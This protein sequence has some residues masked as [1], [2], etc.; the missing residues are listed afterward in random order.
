MN[1][2]RKIIHVDMDCFFAAV[3]IRDNPHLKGRA[4][5]VGGNPEGR[6]VLTTANYE[7]RKYGVKSAMSS[8]QALKLCP[9][10]V[11]T[12][13]NMFKYKNESQKIQTI[14]NKYASLVQPL[15]L[16]EAFLDVSDSEHCGGSATLLAQKIRA[17]I[18][19]VTRLTASAGI[20][21]NKFLAKIASDWKKPNGQYTIGPKD[22]ELF[23]PKLQVQKIPGVGKITAQKMH[24]QNIYT[25]K[26]LQNFSIEQLTNKF[27]SWG[28]KLFDLSR[29]IDNRPVSLGGER[30]SLSI[31]ST[32]SKDLKTV[33]ECVGKVPKLFERFSERLSRANVSDRIKSLFVKVKFHDFKSTT[34][35]TAT[36][37]QVSVDSFAKILEEAY[38]RGNKPVRLIGIGVKL[39]S[40]NKPI[41]STPQLNLF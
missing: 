15:S 39:K 14:F 17:E 22:I 1:K 20:A 38:F 9:H 27:G 12:P 5:A 19:Q 10:L 26:D 30:K 28:C 13:V 18:Y 33:E 23:I 34:L 31:E 32:Y 6:G 41:K 35:E 11:L 3:E 24:E 25:C 21:P 8:A 29:G 4:V 36:L 37:N 16:D 40:K 2:Q 7:A